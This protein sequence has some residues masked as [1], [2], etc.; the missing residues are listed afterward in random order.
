MYVGKFPFYEVGWIEKKREAPLR[1]SP[2]L[3]SPY[4]SVLV[5]RFLFVQV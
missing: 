4:G 5:Q 3:A 2:R 1:R